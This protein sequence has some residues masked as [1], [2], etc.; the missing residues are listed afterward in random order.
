MQS[1]TSAP[2]GT[3]AAAGAA[4]PGLAQGFQATEKRLQKEKAALI[5]KTIACGRV[6]LMSLTAVR[7]HGNAELTGKQRPARAAWVLRGWRRYLSCA[8]RSER[9]SPFV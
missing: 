4:A 1:N 9:P 5:L 3:R 7:W 6:L 2:P 8:E